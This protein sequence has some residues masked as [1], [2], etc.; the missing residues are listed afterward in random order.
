MDIKVMGLSHIGLP[1]ADIDN[2][3]KFYES[4]G[5]ELLV[6]KKNMDGYHYAYLQKG[7]CIIGLPQCLSPE[8]SPQRPSMGAI[9]HLAL[10]CEDIEAAYQECIKAGCRVLSDGIVSNEIW[11]PKR[12]RCFMIEAPDGVRLEVQQIS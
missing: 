1:T 3:I 7:D 11:A 10:A 12:C 8:L 4:L 9:D 5:F 6:L 2:A